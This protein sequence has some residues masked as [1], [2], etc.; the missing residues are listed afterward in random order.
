MRFQNDFELRIVELRNVRHLYENFHYLGRARVGRQIN[1]GIYRKHDDYL[2]GAICYAL[3]MLR[4]GYFDYKSTEMVEFA[5]LYLVENIK[6]LAVWSI[7]QSLQRIVTD[8]TEKFPLADKPQI[9]I[10]YHDTVYHLGTIYKAA[11]FIFYRNT[12]PIRRGKN[13]YGT[14]FKGTRD[15]T[16]DYSHIKGT[17]IYPLNKKARKLVLSKTAR[18]ITI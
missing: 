5:R 1:Y 10:S 16:S 7:A 8:W 9:V 14:N 17:W 4:V 12:K 2:I 11:N 6:G 18:E 3:P 15:Y 13:R